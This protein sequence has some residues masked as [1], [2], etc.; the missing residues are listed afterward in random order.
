M[1]PAVG[2]KTTENSHGMSRIRVLGCAIDALTLEETVREVDRLLRAGE[3]VQ[4]C[5]VNAYKIVLI[6]DDPRLGEFIAN[7]RLVNADG[8]SVVWASRLLGTPLP[9]R[10]AGIDLFEAILSLAER[11]G[12]SVYFL[13]ARE[14]IVTEVAR[15]A[16]ERYPGLR[17]AGTHH[18]Y[19]G[20][21]DGEHVVADV[22]RTRPHVLFVGMPSPQKEYWLGENFARLGVPFAMGVGGSFDVFAGVVRRAPVWMQRSGLEWAYRFYQEPAKMWRRYLVG[23]TRFAV[24]VVKELLGR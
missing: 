2:S 24:L 5:A 14:E 9:E 1:T 15:R 10:V 8:Q 20:S 19:F 12:Y 13:G 21:T 11:E 3:T 17:V 7:C 4:H 16:A 23:N 18:G 6:E 22:Q